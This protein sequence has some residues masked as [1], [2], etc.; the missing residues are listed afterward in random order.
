MSAKSIRDLGKHGSVI[1]GK[2]G[3]AGA[4]DTEDGDAARQEFTGDSGTQAARV[5]GQLRPGLSL[6]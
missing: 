2:F 1:G 4:G 3:V 5:A 6:D